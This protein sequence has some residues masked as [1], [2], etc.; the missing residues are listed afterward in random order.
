MGPGGHSSEQRRAALLQSSWAKTNLM[1]SEV[2]SSSFCPQSHLGRKCQP[3]STV[4]MQTRGDA[5]ADC[6]RCPF[7]HLNSWEGEPLFDLHTTLGQFQELLTEHFRNGLTPN[8][9]VTFLDTQ[10][11][12]CLFLAD[13]SCQQPRKTG[14]ISSIRLF[15]PGRGASLQP[16]PPQ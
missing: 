11:S 3:L 7:P 14:S 10:K 2:S 15:R 4:I 13:P 9:P 5:L 12:P 1:S 8:R 6:R 16:L